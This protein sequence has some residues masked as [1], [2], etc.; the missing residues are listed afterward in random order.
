MVMITFDWTTLFMYIFIMSNWTACLT[1]TKMGAG[2]TGDRK[3]VAKSARCVI[4]FP[5]RLPNISKGIDKLKRYDN[6]TEGW[7][8][9]SKN[10]YMKCY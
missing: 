8:G 6:G 7:S 5:G 2:W 1:V 3:L 9:W 10:T 4:R